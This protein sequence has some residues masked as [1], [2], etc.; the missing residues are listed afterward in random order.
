MDVLEYH[1]WGRTI[2]YD[3]SS[4]QMSKF[5]FHLQGLGICKMLKTFRQEKKLGCQ[6]NECV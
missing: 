2:I 3:Q 5:M 6:K 4:L 1:I